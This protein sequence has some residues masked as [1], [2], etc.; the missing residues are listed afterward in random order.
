MIPAVVVFFSSCFKSYMKLDITSKWEQR[1]MK[2]LAESKKE[3][4]VYF[5][6][7][8]TV[9]SNPVMSQ[10][11]IIGAVSTFQFKALSPL[12]YTEKDNVSPFQKAVEA[13]DVQIFISEE[14]INQ[15][16]VVINSNN[17]IQMREYKMD[18]SATVLSY[19]GSTAGILIVLVLILGGVAY[20]AYLTSTIT[21]HL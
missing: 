17:F 9:I 14:F 1:K 5:L 11:Q 12:P 3:V 2:E 13:P 18:R 7:K 8:P 6:N 16:T 19:M 20:R 4:E 10:G 15:D 21:L